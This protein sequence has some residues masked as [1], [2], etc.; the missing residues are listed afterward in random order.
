VE[1]SPSAPRVLVSF[2][3]A[4]ES[5]KISL[6]HPSKESTLSCDTWQLVSFGRSLEIWFSAWSS[7]MSLIER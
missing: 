5:D 4:N 6:A 7:F 3:E 1:S 2:T